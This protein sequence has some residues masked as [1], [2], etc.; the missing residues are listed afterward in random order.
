MPG[1]AVQT[2]DGRRLTVFEGGDP[3]GLAVVVQH[4]TPGSGLLYAAHER[5]AR[6]QGIR[7][8]GYDRPG[9]G[10]STPATGRSVA[11]AARD[12]EAI[13]DALGLDRFAGWGISGGGPHILACAALC[14]ERL[15]AVASLAS[16]APYEA[17]G[18]DWLGGM[19]QSNVEEFGAVRDGKD[20]ARAY[21]ECERTMLLGAALDELQ[22]AWASLLGEADRFVLDGALAG[23]LLE[24]AKRGLQPAVEGWLDDD[25]AFVAPWGFDVAAVARPVLLVHGRDD[26]FVPVSHGEWLAD[27]IPG[28]EA[29][30]TRDDGHLTL[31]EHRIRDVHEWLLARS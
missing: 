17:N 18:L 3:D 28:A 9:Y 27:R 2:P 22:G 24:S 25:L 11:G 1:R 14:D 16:V 19:G 30:I 8:V 29:R 7:L 5:L 21:L 6:A 13:A 20:A 31:M 10:E 26:R 23:H 15:L 4:G 12:L